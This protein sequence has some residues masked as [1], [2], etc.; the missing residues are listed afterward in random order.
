MAEVR[1]ALKDEFDVEAS[2]NQIAYYNPRSASGGEPAQK[3]QTLFDETREA[4]RS[5]TQD[6]AIAQKRW[7][8]DQLEAGFRRLREADPEAA[9]AL[10]EQAAKETGG[11]YTNEQKHE[12][13]GEVGVKRVG[14]PEEV[15]DPDDD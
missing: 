7:R 12:H 2:I 10:L 3:W 8:L 5:K 9:A 4:Y 13:S 15:P 14:Y 11:K 6:V 1:E